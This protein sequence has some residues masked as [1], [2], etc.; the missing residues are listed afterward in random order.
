MATDTEQPQ[1]RLKE[2][3]AKGKERGFLT[4]AEVNDHLPEDIS[5]PDQI[6]DII[7][8]IND[9]GITVYEAAPDPDELLNAEENTADELAAEEAAA[10]LAALETKAGRTTDP[11]RMY[12]RE[13]GTVGLLTRKG[14]IRIAKHIEEGLDQVKNALTY[15]PPTVDALMDAYAPVKEGAGRLRGVLTGF[16]DPNEPDEVIPA[17]VKDEADEEEEDT[18]PDPVEADK[19]LQSIFRRHKRILSTIE[20]HG[21]ADPKTQRANI[22]FGSIAAIFQGSPEIGA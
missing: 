18:G 20:K 17:S 5:G 21:T 14:E 7:R 10:V 2:L 8:M 15:F 13:M 19:R 6:N 4:Y 16:I 3:I 11:V 9:L 12:M 22:R 1:S